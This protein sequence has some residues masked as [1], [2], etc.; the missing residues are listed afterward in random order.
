MKMTW[1]L[2]ATVR[3]TDCYSTN[4]ADMSRSIEQNESVLDISITFS[5]HFNVNQ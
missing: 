3:N 4:L 5:D 2:P 1:L